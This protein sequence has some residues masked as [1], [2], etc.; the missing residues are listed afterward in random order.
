MKMRKEKRKKEGKK[1]GNEALLR[2]GSI[3]STLVTQKG[4]NFVR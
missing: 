2:R 3:L 1:E 4:R